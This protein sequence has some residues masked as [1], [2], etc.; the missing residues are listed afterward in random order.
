MNLTEIAQEI[1][2]CVEIRKKELELTFYEDE[3]IYFMRDLD[4]NHRNNFPSVSKVIKSFYIPFDAETKATQMTGGDEEETR[5]LLE[6]WKKAGD[7]S[8]NLGSRVHYML[9]NDLVDRY[10]KYK[11][12]RQ[13]IFECDNVQITRSNQMIDAGKQFI[14]LM[15]E[16]G[17]VLLDTEMVLGDPELGYVGQ[18]DKM[19]LMMNKQKDGFGIVVTDWKTNQ[20][21][22]FQIQPY[23]SKML[24]PFE[25]YYDTALSHYFVQLP[26][27]GKLLLKMLE[28][29]KFSDVKL[30]GCVI[31]H[32]KDNGTFTEYKVP[33]DMTNSILQMDI[34]NYLK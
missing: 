32:L 4:G 23:T 29:S 26:L 5:I 15:H 1:R 34:K 30:L 22:N 16:R 3:H 27:Y 6:K 17:A 13:P 10:N 21:K 28:T 24:H 11:E 25:N 31:T 14:D 2:E 20:E 9:E 7:Y 19:W 12:V 8:T 18:P 33:S